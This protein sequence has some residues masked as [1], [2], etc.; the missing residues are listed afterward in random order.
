MTLP[1]SEAER[2]RQIEGV[3]V[4][5]VPSPSIVLLAVNLKG[6]GRSGRHHA[7]AVERHRAEH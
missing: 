6:K 2:V 1:V 5:S 4:V 3:T 7:A